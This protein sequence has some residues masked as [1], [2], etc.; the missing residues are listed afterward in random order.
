M[1]KKV[2]AGLSRLTEFGRNYLVSDSAA[3]ARDD[4]EFYCPSL[5]EYGTR[6]HDEAA[7]EV[8][9]AVKWIDQGGL[10]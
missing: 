8:R 10:S 1:T 5:G 9:A 6:E 4:G 3:S 7:A 2:R